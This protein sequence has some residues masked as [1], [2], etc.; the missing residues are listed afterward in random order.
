MKLRN[1]KRNINVGIIVI[2]NT[3]SILRLLTRIVSKV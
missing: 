2:T 1:I 3:I